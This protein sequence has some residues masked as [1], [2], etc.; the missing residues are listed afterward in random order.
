MFYFV[1]INKVVYHE[2]INYWCRTDNINFGSTGAY[3]QYKKQ[4]LT[5]QANKLSISLWLFQPCEK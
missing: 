1:L 3:R 5:T 4:Q 2:L